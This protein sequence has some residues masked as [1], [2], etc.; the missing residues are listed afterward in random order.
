MTKDNSLG[1]GGASRVA[2]KTVFG[3]RLKIGEAPA[4]MFTGVVTDDRDPQNM[5]RV[6][7][8]IEGFSV[9]SFRVDHAPAASYSEYALTFSPVLPF[10]GSDDNEN[11]DGFSQSYGMWYQPRVGDHVIVT[12][13]NGS[14]A[15]GFY[16]GCIQK[17]SQTFQTPGAA[18]NN[19]TGETEKLPSTETPSGSTPGAAK[20]TSVL[21]ENLKASGLI[22]D[23]I[24][25]GGD[26]SQRRESPSELFGVKTRG[27][28][29]LGM[30]GHQFVMDDLPESQG[31]RL[32][33]STGNQVLLSD[34]SNSVYISTNRGNTWLELGADGEIGVFGSK[35]ISVH[36]EQDI[37]LVADRDLNLDVGRDINAKVG[38]KVNAKVV[39]DINLLSQGRVYLESENE[40]DVYA[41]GDIKMTTTGGRFHTSA[42]GDI[43]LTSG[44][45]THIAS[46]DQIRLHSNDTI[47]S[48]DGAETAEQADQ[49]T[50]PN[51]AEQVGPPSTSERQTGTLGQKKIY[52]GS[53]DNENTVPQHE[54]WDRTGNTGYGSRTKYG[55]STSSEASVDTTPTP[56]LPYES[57]GQPLTPGKPLRTS[58]PNV[59]S[60]IRFLIVH[61][62]ANRP[63][64]YGSTALESIDRFHKK[65]GWSGIGYN[66]LIDSSGS[67]REG[68]KIG[69]RGIHTAGYN[70]KSVGVCMVGG[71]HS[72]ATWTHRGQQRPIPYPDYS[73]SQ[74][75]QLRETLTYLKTL[76]PRAVVRGHNDFVR[77]TSRNKLCPCF[78]VSHWWET[79][80]VVTDVGG[81]W[82]YIPE[83]DR[84]SS[85]IHRN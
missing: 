66:V 39:E 15:D 4:G 16:L 77:G 24:R 23:P 78:N 17:Y 54:P 75:E 6:K 84:K 59:A 25:G 18:I 73:D 60:N 31:I 22:R 47:H 74:L 58:V 2:K 36:A 32:R 45:A 7:V 34:A 85:V 52:V 63:G 41:G 42:D 26:A 13:A 27:R 68:V 82:R 43:R 70:S 5:G 46:S 14:T 65:R 62:S 80:E 56:A 21:A 29:D 37:N 64:A 35:S 76:Y 61:C 57:K 10:A 3:R 33:T 69:H 9:P 48:Q 30:I 53:R 71:F 55:S 50:P 11:K 20:A 79:G 51:E 1:K 72:S 67:A 38:S 8:Y 12:F 83:G 81:F 40:L 28:S 19:V 44:S 49:S